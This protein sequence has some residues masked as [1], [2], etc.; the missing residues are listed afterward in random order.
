M[1]VSKAELMIG[2]IFEIEL[3]DRNVKVEI[4]KIG[5][6]QVDIL[7]DEKEGVCFM[8]SLIPFKLTDNMLVDDYKFQR[9][10]MKISGEVINDLLKVIGDYFVSLNKVNDKYSLSITS[11]NGEKVCESFNIEYLH[12]LQN[13]I[14]SNIKLEITN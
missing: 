12:T 7:V 11:M 4:F 1:I 14:R 9:R 10:N 5:D 8:D 6:K 13:I 3:R 2:D